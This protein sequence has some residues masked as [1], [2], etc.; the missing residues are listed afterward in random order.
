M[1]ALLSLWDSNGFDPKKDIPK[2]I[3]VL[4][5]VIADWVRSYSRDKDGGA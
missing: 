5:V 2:L 1:I 3:V 4:A